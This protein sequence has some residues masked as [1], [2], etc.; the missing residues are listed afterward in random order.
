[1]SKAVSGLTISTLEITGIL[2]PIGNSIRYPAGAE[3]Y[4][5]GDIVDQV[6]ALEEG[7]VGLFA[8]NTEGGEFCIGYRTPCWI[9]GAACL[10]PM[11]RSVVSIRTLCSCRLRQISS[12]LFLSTVQTSPRLSIWMLEMLSEELNYQISASAL[13]SVHDLSRRLQHYIWTLT[14]SFPAEYCKIRWPFGQKSVAQLLG[15]SESYISTKLAGLQSLGLI[16]RSKGWMIVPKR[17]KLWHLD[18]SGH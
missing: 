17:S 13:T 15:T 3:I 4:A 14:K 11:R 16:E 12:S 9:A 2:Q 7:E 6:F 8:S 10:F 1:M 18:S 5:Q